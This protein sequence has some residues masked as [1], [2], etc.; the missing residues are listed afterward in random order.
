MNILF[1][2]LVHIS[3]LLEKNFLRTFPELDIDVTY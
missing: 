3:I 2:D 1:K